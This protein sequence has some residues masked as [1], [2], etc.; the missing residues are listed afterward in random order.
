MKMTAKAKSAQQVIIEE[1]Y[2]SIKK[3]LTNMLV[4]NGEEGLFFLALCFLQVL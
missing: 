2:T 1:K 4:T 3:L